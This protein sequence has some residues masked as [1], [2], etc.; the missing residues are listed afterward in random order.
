M[1][2][3]FIIRM[4]FAMKPANLPP[5]QAIPQIYDYDIFSL[6]QRK[7][8]IFQVQFKAGVTIE[9]EDVEELMSM[10]INQKGKG[11]C[12]LLVIFQE[13]NSFTNETREYMA[14]D[15][16]S[17]IIQASALVVK[18]LA[19]EILGNGYIRINKPSRPVRLFKSP[20]TAVEWLRTFQVNDAVM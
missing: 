5:G 16:V 13:D 1:G 2:F 8:K 10:I 11:K 4:F 6:Y 18:G 12:L 17:K 9:K 7:D 20:V 3:N 19:L 15:E 14:S